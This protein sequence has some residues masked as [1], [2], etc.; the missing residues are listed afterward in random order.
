MKKAVFLFS[1][2]VSF[3]SVF[4][5][6]SSYKVVSTS[7]AQTVIDVTIGEVKQ[8]PVSTPKGNEVKI[9][10]GK[11]TQL[12]QK[13]YPDL[14]KLAFSIIIP[15]QANSHI[16][17][18]ESQYTDIPLVSVAPSKGTLSRD[19]DPS[20]VPF[21]YDNIYQKNA[22]FPT[23]AAVL[24]QPYI[25]RDFRGQTVMIHPVQYNPVTKTLR[26]YSHVKVKVDY[27]GAS[28]ENI[29]SS[30]QWPDAVV[31]EF[32]GIYQNQFINYK[33]AGAPFAPIAEQGSLLVLSPAAYLGELPSFIKWKNMKGIKTFLVNTDTLSGGANTTTLKALIKTYY[34]EKQ[35]AYVLLVGDNTNLPPITTSGVVAGPSDNAYA[36]INGND[37]YPELIMGRFSGENAGDIRTQVNRTLQYEQTPNT[38][39]NWMRTQLGISSGQGP[40]DDNQYDFA[41]IHDIVDSNKNQYH[42]LTNIEQYDDTCTL[43]ST[44]LGTDLLGWP[45]KTMFKDAV[46]A[47][48]GLIN[49]CGHGFKDGINTTG[50][51]SI[52]IPTLTNINQLPFIYVVGCSPGEFVSYTCFAENLQRATT[53]SNQAFGTISN[54]MATIPQYWDEPMQAQDEFN[55]ILRGARPSNL[56]SRLGAMCMDACMS[57][58]DQYN[59]ATDPLAGSDMTDTWI[60]FGDPTVSLYTKNAGTLTIGHDIHIKQN[61]TSWEV[62]CPVDG[63]T[64]GLYYQGAY[65]ASSV[66]NGG[67]AYFNFPGLVNLDTVFITATKQNYVPAMSNALVVNWATP[68]TDINTGNNLSMYPNPTTDRVYIQLKDNSSLQQIDIL[69][70]TGNVVSSEK[71]KGNTF[72]ISTTSFASGVYILRATTDKGV[73]RKTFTKR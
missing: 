35:I 56:K 15:N 40:G 46:N 32:D 60:F 21:V 70:A 54:F 17:I 61:S 41:H 64:I 10:V 72:S 11:G 33:T 27:D 44:L 34:Q 48:A 7:A 39:G 47:G 53:S 58:N 65:L 23:Q 20:S 14:P 59:I 37:H 38:S 9:T 63:A 57:M 68:V 13:G 43:T 5:Q 28:S 66:V 4:A 69:D 67:M 3:H 6:T 22:F 52:D 55:A 36:Y 50:F 30:N 1:V 25:L 26:V 29:L 45:T 71:A 62:H 31:E 51:Q 18:L 8:V 2:L 12:L 19:I 49:Y 42:Y 73:V 24:N 16:S